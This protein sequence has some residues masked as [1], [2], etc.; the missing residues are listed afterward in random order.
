MGNENED[1]SD[2]EVVLTFADIK[3]ALMGL[4]TRDP[5]A[6]DPIWLASP[7]GQAWC[8]KR[9]ADRAAHERGDRK[10]VILNDGSAI[11]WLDVDRLELLALA[12]DGWIFDDDTMAWAA[13]GWDGSRPWADDP[14]WRRG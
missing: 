7:A 14:T 13:E 10:L 11:K 12:D 5:E 2:H 4:I 1:G 6:P 8:A 9:A 3:I